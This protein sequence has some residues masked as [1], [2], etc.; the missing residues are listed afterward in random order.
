MKAIKGMLLAVVMIIS[1]A[2]AAQTTI[3]E[4]EYWIDGAIGARQALS[5]GASINISSLQPGLHTLTVRVKDSNGLWSNQMA[6]IFF[7]MPSGR[8]DATSVTACEYWIDD[9]KKPEYT[10]LNIQ[11]IDISDLKPGLHKIL[12]RTKDNLGIWSN[13]I[14]RIFFVMPSGRTDATSVTACEY[15]IDGVKKSEYATLNSQV[16]DISDLK[17]GLHKILVRT[18]DNLGIWSNQIA[19]IFFVTPSGRTD[20]TSV[21]ACEYWIDGVKKSEYATLNSQVIDI[22]DLKHGL[23]KI[24]V[25]TKD[26]LGIWSNQMSRTFFVAPGAQTDATTITKRE[27]WLDGNIALR[28]T[29]DDTPTV[30]DISALDAG[31]HMLTMRVQD[32][33]GVWS[34]QMARLFFVAPLPD[35]T[36]YVLTKY[37]YWFDKDTEHAVIGDINE[38]NGELVIDI[39]MLSHDDD[40]H[41]FHLCVCDSRGVWSDLAIDRFSELAT[42]N[43]RIT[44]NLNNGEWYDLSGKKLSAPP[45]FPGIYI[46]DGKKVILR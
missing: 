42:S 34:N 2:A 30:I 3:A 21:T 32:D 1:T 37:M 11:T 17:P 19:R 45:R 12:V 18:K 9:V 38:S 46:H 23:H 36:E 15:W 16:I 4:G 13:Q 27:F 40:E 24:L 6:R 10:T 22:S 5:S 7:V 20:A 43:G 33:K 39:E 29:I 44:I 14:A 35:A 41:T 31:L 28:Q 26:N 25:R 8:T